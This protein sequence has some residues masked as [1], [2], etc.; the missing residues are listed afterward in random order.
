MMSIADYMKEVVIPIIE[1][2]VVFCLIIN[3]SYSYC[4]YIDSWLIRI[5]LWYCCTAVVVISFGIKGNEKRM[6]IDVIRNK[7]IH[8]K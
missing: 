8:K 5:I 2:C 6:C 4:L 7:I 1:V 3:F